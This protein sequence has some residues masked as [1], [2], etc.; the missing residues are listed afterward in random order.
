MSLNSLTLK[1]TLPLN[2][3]HYYSNK[4]Y[5]S[6]SLSSIDN[7]SFIK[8][9]MIKND[10]S[11]INISIVPNRTYL[12][13]GT[14]YDF[15]KGNINEYYNYYNKRHNNAYFLSSN[16]VASSYGISKDF[17]NI[18]YTTIPTLEQIEKPSL[19]VKW[20]YP[21]YYIPGLRGTNIKYKLNKDLFLLDIGDIKNVQF[22]WNAI[23]TIDTIDNDKKEEYKEL[24]FNTCAKYDKTLGFKKP[25]NECKRTS[26]SESDDEL[27]L[28]FQKVLIPFIKSTN[29]INIDG[30]VYYN[31]DH[32]HEEILVISNLY[33][34]FVN[35]ST[36]KATK[37][38][39][40]PTIEEFTASVESKKVQHSKNIKYNTVLSNV[41]NIKPL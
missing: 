32:F 26:N 11:G 7:T 14:N 17:T 41:Y 37:Y 16:K 34:D 27:V 29:D 12:Y 25:P 40:I 22:I 35:T 1:K 19:S 4:K 8:S 10:V 31:T 6:Y 30:W 23:D 18:V 5:K 20:I 13:Q 2:N 24:L 21:L 39:N 33:L 9:F 36:L 3:S 38:D 15:T 28:F